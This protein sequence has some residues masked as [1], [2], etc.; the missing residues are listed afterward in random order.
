[1][2]VCSDCGFENDDE[3]L[4]C[5]ACGE[6]LKG[7]AKIMRDA[8]KM[9]EKKEAEAEAKKEAEKNVPLQGRKPAHDEE[10]EFKRRPPKKKDNFDALLIGLAMVAFVILVICGW[11][12]F[13]YLPMGR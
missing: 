2:A 8:E 7:D 12:I 10:Y 4:F 9:K 13:N 3:R 6:P 1:M 11:Y 5:G